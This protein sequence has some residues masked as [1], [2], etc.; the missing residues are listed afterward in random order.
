[1]LIYESQL[2]AN[3]NIGSFY[4]YANSKLRSRSTVGALSDNNGGLITDSFGKASILQQT[5]ANNFTTDNG[6]LPKVTNRMQSSNSLSHIY[7]APALI[8]RAI[9]RLKH[10]TKGGPDCI[11][12]TFFINCCDELCYPLSLLF[13]LSFENSILPDVWLISFV[14]PIFK[15]G[16]P[17]DA[18]NYR[19]IALTATMCKLME[20]VI[21]EQM[22]QFLVDKGR[23]N[24]RQHA[25]IKHHSTASNLLECVR[26]WSIGLN[27]SKQTDVIYI[28]FAK[29]FDS[30]VPS[31]LLLKLEMYGISG[32]LL[33][34]L[35]CFFA[36]LSNRTQCVIIDYCFSPTC[37]VISGVP[38]G[39]V[40]GPLLFLVYINDI[41]S[42]CCGSTKLQLFADD[43]KLYSEI[44]ICNG[45]LTLQQSL[46]RLA[47][48]ASEW[49]LT[50]N[51]NKCAVLS[52]SSKSQ[53]TS[54]AYFIGGLAIS[55]LNSY[56]DLGITISSNLLFEQHINN[57]V[58]KARQRISILLRGFLSC[59]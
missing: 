55:R 23:I 27:Y 39:S 22:V 3:A 5:F 51:I 46:D 45:S 34:W 20:S 28:D 29:A 35:R 25:F 15:K 12:P 6:I 59:I 24:K 44:D 4:R 18:N 8:R 48:W 26:D 7:F 54:H 50:I 56:V 13:T 21:K 17:A 58:S 32:R 42:V 47:N 40:L 38:Q 52:I 33:D 37:S 14:T 53:P 41:D 30:I 9:K 19:P 57:I 31:K 1:M 11:P 2:I 36:F 43:A 10:K 49:Q 16:N